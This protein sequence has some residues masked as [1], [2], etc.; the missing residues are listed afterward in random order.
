MGGRESTTGLIDIQGGHYDGSCDNTASLFRIGREWDLL[1]VYAEAHYLFEQSS[2]VMRG[3]FLNNIAVN[4][5]SLDPSSYKFSLKHMVRETA[6]L[7]LLSELEL[8]YFY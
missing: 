2:W 5:S 3:T 7:T 6:E 1:S 4:L 8:I